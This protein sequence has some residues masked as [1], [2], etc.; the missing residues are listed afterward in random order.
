MKLEGSDPHFKLPGHPFHLN[1]Y[2][3]EKVACIHYEIATGQVLN[4]SFVKFP[5]NKRE[6]ALRTCRYIV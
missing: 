1:V 6:I 4:S 5:I 3:S 2:S